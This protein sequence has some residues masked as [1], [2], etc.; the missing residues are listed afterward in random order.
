MDH[1]GMGDMSMN[2][3][4]MAKRHYTHMT[5]FWGK[6]SEIL[7][8]GWPGTRGGMYALA[9]LLVF[10]LSFLVEWLNHCR[11]IRP[12]TGHVA[13]GLART[14]LHAA[15]VG[16]AYLVMLAV[17]SFN[18]GVLIAAVVGHAVGFLL[19]GS[20]VFRKT[21]LQPTDNDGLKGDLPPM[22]C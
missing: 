9:L 16:L 7:F 8:S 5:F 6:N 22:A 12:G 15:R 13:A 3:S 4:N 19:F 18:G 21:P 1:G 17:M 10:A 2:N 11:L 20:S 14:T